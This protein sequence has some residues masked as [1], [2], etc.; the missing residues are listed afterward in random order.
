MVG[1]RHLI[2]TCL[3]LEAAARTGAWG[4][5]EELLAD[6]DPRMSEVEAA[7]DL[8]LQEIPET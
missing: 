1:A 2:E 7:T 3:R 8:L 5:I 4:R 6:L